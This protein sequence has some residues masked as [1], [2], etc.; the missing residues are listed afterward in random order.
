M[1]PVPLTLNALAREAGEHCE[2]KG[3]RQDWHDA[4]FLETLAAG[5]DREED[6]L[7]TIPTPRGEKVKVA[8]ELR[9]IAETLRTLV[10][11]TKLGLIASEAAEAMDVLR[12]E[13]LEGVRNTPW[14]S[15]LADI[16]IRT[17]ELE[18]ITGVDA[19]DSVM[20][21]VEKNKTRPYMHGKKF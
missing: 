11:M 4:E 13:G 2:V 19:N 18:D 5:L 1:N 15:E 7:Y 8:D 17:A 10:L 20:A 9:R 21:K 3:F 6:P 14:A 16:H 12:R